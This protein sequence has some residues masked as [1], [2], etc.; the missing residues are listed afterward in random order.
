MKN[1]LTVNFEYK[2]LRLWDLI[3]SK[4]NRKYKLTLKQRIERL[5]S[6]MRSGSF[7]LEERVDRTNPPTGASILL[8]VLSI[9]M[10]LF[11]MYVLSNP[12]SC[13]LVI[14]LTK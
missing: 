3:R 6:W 9:I 11:L 12:P 1:K 13:S 14:F 4:P 5:V 2:V 8:L 10:S 7:S